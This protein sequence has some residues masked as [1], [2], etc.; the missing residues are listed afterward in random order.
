M[1]FMLFCDFFVLFFFVAPPSKT[2]TTVAFCFWINFLI[3]LILFCFGI[4]DVSFLEQQYTLDFGWRICSERY[5]W[6]SQ[7]A[8]L[9]PHHYEGNMKIVGNSSGCWDKQI[10]L[11]A[12]EY[13]LSFA[14]AQNLGVL[15]IS[16]IFQ[17]LLL[18][19]KSVNII[20]RS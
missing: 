1:T 6:L 5:Q 8:G 4:V 9:A 7:A 13:Q 3:W 18:Q 15:D 2:F 20:P 10:Y 14:S 16:P 19:E 17:W 12:Q 11:P